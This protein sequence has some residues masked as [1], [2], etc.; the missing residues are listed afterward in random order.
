MKRF[1]KLTAAILAVV[2]LLS[3]IP[4]LALGETPEKYLVT[5][6]MG[7]AS[8]EYLGVPVAGDNCYHLNGKIYDT[9]GK[10]LF[11]LESGDYFYGI[12]ND[13]VLVEDQYGDYFVYAV[14]PE[15]KTFE[16]FGPYIEASVYVLEDEPEYDMVVVLSEAGA[17]VFLESKTLKFE[18][19]AVE[20]C[21]GGMLYGIDMTQ[22]PETAADIKGTLIDI[23]TE[24]TYLVEGGVVM[25]AF[26]KNSDYG[27]AITL[28]ENSELGLGTVALDR[29]GKPVF[30]KS[31]ACLYGSIGG[32]CFLKGDMTSNATSIVNKDGKEIMNLEDPPYDIMAYAFGE[33]EYIVTE[34][35]D[36]ESDTNTY[37]IYLVDSANGTLGEKFGPYETVYPFGDNLFAVT[38]EGEGYRFTGA[39]AAAL[40]EAYFDGNEFSYDGHGLLLSMDSDG[41]ISMRD[42]ALELI[43]KL[44]PSYVE[45]YVAGDGAVVLKD[46]GKS[47]VLDSMGNTLLDA[48]YTFD[49]AYVHKFVGG[50]ILT[51]ATYI[52]ENK[53]GT[54]VY[55]SVWQDTPFVDVKQDSW[56]NSSVKTMFDD[57]IMVGTTDTKFD[58]NGIVSRYQFVS[59]LYRLN[60]SPAVTGE[61]PFSDV[62]AGKWYSNAVLWAVQNNIVAGYSDGKFHGSDAITRQQAAA[63]LYRYTEFVGGAVDG[64]ADLSTFADEGKISPWAEDSISWAVSEEL[65]Y[66]TESGGKM[67][68][69]PTS[70]CTRAEAAAIIARYVG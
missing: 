43:K 15:N 5:R 42:K 37:E 54:D 17:T 25:V 31:D 47:G 62:E 64:R 26:E 69:N 51:Q 45:A 27:T 18:N 53:F 61:I 46:N 3:V 11:K 2:L 63:F 36:S 49:D 28:E 34:L 48:K 32:G 23:A 8:P 66:G 16:K 41:V 4:T 14:D 13:N 6:K 29:M 38:S 40:D 59:I 60:G 19:Y 1:G 9:N 20:Y 52:N 44:D 12:A 35:Y 24:A 68:L 67:K 39:A 55:L 21:G 70:T 50:N 56:Y 7:E 22:E 10:S 65:L 33:R 57:G 58:P 30:E